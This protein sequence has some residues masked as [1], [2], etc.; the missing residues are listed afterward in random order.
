MRILF[1]DDDHIRHSYFTLWTQGHDV[2]HVDTAQ[3]A[4]D[5]IAARYGTGSGYDLIFLD[6]DLGGRTFVS[7][8]EEN[9]G[10]QVARFLSDKLKS[11]QSQ[12]RPRIVVHSWNPAGAERMVK[13]LDAAGYKVDWRTFGPSMLDGLL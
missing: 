4:K 10:Y 11:W 9:T 12:R 6:H 7:S 1:L 5:A 13:A 3:Q 2:R 8:E